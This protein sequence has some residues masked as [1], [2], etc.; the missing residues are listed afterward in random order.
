MQNY[1]DLVKDLVYLPKSELK[2]NRTGIATKAISGAML[3]FDMRNGFPIVTTRK[4]YIH[5]ALVELEFFIKGLTDKRWLKLYGN[6]FWN[7]HA[8][9]TKAKYGTDELSRK[10]MQEENDL[11]PI[12][13][14]QWRRWG[15][16]YDAYMKDGGIGHRFIDQLTNVLST[17]KKNPADRRMIVSAWDPTQLHQMALPPCHLL[18]Q[19]VVTGEKLDTLNLNWYQRSC[20]IMI[21]V[22]YDII[23][24]GALLHILAHTTGMKPGYLCGMLGDVHIYE[25]HI[26]TAKQ[27]LCRKPLSLPHVYFPSDDDIDMKSFHIYDWEAENF[28]LLDYIYHPALKFEMAV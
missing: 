6:K 19:V 27:Q 20:D 25:N 13:G 18:W 12:Y 8:N 14:Y 23:L 22:P 4:M 11:G 3:K 10:A 2:P 5:N 28:E 16:D 17:L 9:P 21:G 24:Y 7:Y 1:L 15:L 26:E